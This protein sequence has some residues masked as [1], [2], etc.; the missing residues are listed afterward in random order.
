M[1]VAE[2]QETVLLRD[3]GQDERDRA[4][5][6]QP[7]DDAHGVA[8]QQRRR[9][10]EAQLVDQFGGG[11]LG[12]KAG[13]ALDE[14]VVGVP[15]VPS[16]QGGQ[17]GQ[18]PLR[19]SPPSP[20]GGSTS[21]WPT[22]P[23][24]TSAPPVPVP[25]AGSGR[26]ACS[27]IGT[28]RTTFRRREARPRRVPR[29]SSA[30]HHCR[31]DARGRPG[32]DR[33]HR[34]PS[35][36]DD[37]ERR[38]QPGR[39]RL[40]ALPPDVVHGARRLR[41]QR[42]RWSCRGSAPAQPR[43]GRHRG[44]HGAGTLGPPVTSSGSCDAWPCRSRRRPSSSTRDRLEPPRRSSGSGRRQI[45]WANASAAPTLAL[46]LP[47]GLD[48]T[49]RRVAA[50]CITADATLTLALP[51]TGLHRA[52]QVVGVRYVADVSVPPAN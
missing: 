7:V 34:D 15:S 20:F 33:R 44:A 21:R 51:K 1:P 50:P 36:P 5:Q 6:G 48:A 11:E 26:A 14:D 47:S 10:R 3:M 25:W 16:G 17:G 37:G 32:D 2:E 9:H 30:G 12:V 40:G 31:P 35:P 43:R 8:A 42:G 23:T 24:S 45:E 46:D 13:A 19:P 39:A 29:G 49:T 41:G 22:D 38:A 18:G 4:V 28:T 52:P 27:A